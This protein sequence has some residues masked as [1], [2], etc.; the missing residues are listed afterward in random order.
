[1]KDFRERFNDETRSGVRVLLDNSK[2]HALEAEFP[3]AV[4]MLIS[5]YRTR[6]TKLLPFALDNGRYSSYST[7][8]EWDVVAW[9]R[10]LE[11]GE[12]QQT[13]PTWAIV[14]DVV[15][16]AEA[17]F[18]EWDRLAHVVREQ[19][20]FQTAL[21]V[22]DG[23]TPESVRSRI[24]DPGVIFVGGSTAWKWRT[25]WQWCRSFPRVHIG[26]VN[27]YR[28]L[29]LAHRCGAESVDGTGWFRGDKRQ[30]AGLRQYL[31]EAWGGYDVPQLELDFA[32]TFGGSV[33]DAS[34]VIS[35]NEVAA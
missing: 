11:F 26:R 31:R 24:G 17:T 29:I 10:L 1:M 5:P 12:N 30:E 6:P 8:R 3:G 33:P 4:G 13:R 23:M 16:D 7:G 18:R 25:A 34:F 27:G 21:A 2:A 19:Y 35:P 22:Q 28:W 20:G 15:T 9:N 32:R 14:P